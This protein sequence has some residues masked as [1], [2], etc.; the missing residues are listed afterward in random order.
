MIE[1]VWGQQQ[2]HKG[3]GY[4]QSINEETQWLKKKDYLDA[5]EPFS[6]HRDTSITACQSVSQSPI[7]TY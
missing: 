3:G 7:I 6:H 1:D 2:K 4:V 5:D